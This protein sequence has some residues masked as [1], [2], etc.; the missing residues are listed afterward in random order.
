[1]AISATASSTASGAAERLA[2]RNSISML[3]EWRKL[4][5][6]LEIQTIIVFLLIATTPGIRMKEIERA[7]GLSSSAVSR[8]VL[9]LS[10]LGWRR[11]HKGKQE[12]GLDFIVTASD[13]FDARA[14]V[15]SLNTRGRKFFV[16]LADTM[17]GGR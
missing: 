17:N 4:S 15:A 12:P 13:P 14:K 16:K 5:P 1:M 3:E 6:S 9:A 8:N 7:T 2:A 10:L 11:D